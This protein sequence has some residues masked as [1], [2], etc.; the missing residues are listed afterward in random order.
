MGDG[1]DCICAWLLA[2][3]CRMLY[4]A[5]ASFLTYAGIVGMVFDPQ[6]P[7]ITIGLATAAL[8]VSEWWI[9]K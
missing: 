5:G 4:L 8:V 9:R 6:M 3:K 2:R 1:C 7:D